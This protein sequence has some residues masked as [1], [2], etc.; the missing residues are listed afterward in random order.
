MVIGGGVAGIQAAL[1]LAD[2][3]VETFLV[4]SEPSIGGRMAQLDKT[5]PTNDCAMC[6]LSPKLVQAGDHPYITILSNSVVTGISGTPPR[7]SVTVVKK[8][9]YVDEAKCTGCGTCVTKC[10]VKVPDPYNK[11]LSQTKAIRIPFPQAVPA[12]AVIDAQKCLYLRKGTCRLCQKAC[13]TNAIDFAQKEETVAIDVGSVILASG[14]KEFDAKLKAEYGYGVF[15]ERGHQYR[16][17]A[18]PFRIR[19]HGQGI[20]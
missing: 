20:L 13:G 15:P 16:I 11:G 12:V 1:D 8:P 18:V 7:L 6:I 10:P 3:G 14:T 2:M 4:E 17:R 5:F 9:R 19:S